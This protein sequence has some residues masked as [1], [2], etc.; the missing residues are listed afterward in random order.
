MRQQSANR[1]ETSAPAARGG[2]YLY[3][4]ECVDGTWYTGYTVNVEQRLKTHNAGAGAKYTR[5]RLPVH[6]VAQA[7]FDTKHEA[8]SAEYHFKHLSRLQKE[9]LVA[10]SAHKSF[11]QLLHSL[12]DGAVP[13]KD[14]LRE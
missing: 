5:A 6:L 1:G 10:Q 7:A 2:H 13:K 9:H 11:A 14:T 3:V 8:M 4:V 12:T